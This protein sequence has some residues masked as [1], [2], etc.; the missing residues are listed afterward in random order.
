MTIPGTGVKNAM[1]DRMT[2]QEAI[3]ELK[4][5]CEQL[6]KSVPCDTSWGQSINTAYGMAVAALEKQIPK[7]PILD[8]IYHHNYYCPNCENFLVG[9]NGNKPHHC[10]CGQALDWSEE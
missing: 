2:E 7:K 8:I 10:K 9:K 4:Y 6:G 5:D 3:E 1:G